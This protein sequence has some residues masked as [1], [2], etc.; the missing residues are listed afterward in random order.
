MTIHFNCLQGRQFEK[1]DRIDS[2]QIGFAV[3]KE[4]MSYLDSLL[5]STGYWASSPSPYRP[6]AEVR[7]ARNYEK[8][9]MKRYTFVHCHRNEIWRFTLRCWDFVVKHVIYYF[10]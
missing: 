10:D 5:N 9:K 1:T 8:E 6:L 3:K 7:L 4:E 2:K